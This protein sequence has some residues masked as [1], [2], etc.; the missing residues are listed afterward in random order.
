MGHK[1]LRW[2]W[3]M[4]PK[5]SALWTANRNYSHMQAGENALLRAS[6]RPYLHAISSASQRGGHWQDYL[7]VHE[8]LDST[9][10][11]CP[12]IRHRMILHSEA[13][14]SGKCSSGSIP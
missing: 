10:A 5:R 8:F 12:D 9:K 1:P 14:Q 4:R 3:L 13:A 6:M 2:L 11:S 7:A